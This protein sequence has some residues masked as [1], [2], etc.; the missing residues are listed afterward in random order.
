MDLNT[1][2]RLNKANWSTG[3]QWAEKFKKGK[4]KLRANSQFFYCVKKKWTYMETLG[5]IEKVGQ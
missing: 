2:W 5:K 3:A 1:W 4:N